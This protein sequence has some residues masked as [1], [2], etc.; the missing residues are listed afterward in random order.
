MVPCIRSVR[1]RKVGLFKE[2]ETSICL[3]GLWYRDVKAKTHTANNEA[4]MKNIVVD[5][6]SEPSAP[7]V[8]TT[9]DERNLP[10]LLPDCWT[11]IMG[12]C[13]A[14]SLSSLD[15]TSR[16]FSRQTE[17]AWNH[18]AMMRFGLQTKSSSD[19]SSCT[20]QQPRRAKLHA[21]RRGL[22]LT[23]P[24]RFTLVEL[25][26]NVESGKE[27]RATEVAQGGGILVHNEEDQEGETDE[28][29]T[30]HNPLFL[31]DATTL[32][33][34]RTLPNPF[35]VWAVTVC[36]MTDCEIVVTSNATE[37]M[38]HRGDRS[39]TIHLSDYDYESS[40]FRSH[41]AITRTGIGLLGSEKSLVV[42][43]GGTLYVF[44]VA[45]PGG[46]DLPL[47]KFTFSVALSGEALGSHAMCWAC[48]DLP[49]SFGMVPTK[50][51]IQVWHLS[52]TCYRP[53]RVQDIAYRL[54]QVQD[55]DSVFSCLAVGQRYIAAST[56]DDGKKI[57]VFDRGNGLE[58]WALG[59]DQT[60]T[61]QDCIWGISMQIVGDLLVSSSQLGNAL[62]IWQM[63]TGTLLRRYD[64]A[65]HQGIS[66]YHWRYPRGED[67]ISL[68]RLNTFGCG[69][70][71]TISF[72]MFLWA[73]PEDSDSAFR[74]ECLARRERVLRTHWRTSANRSFGSQL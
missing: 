28:N 47:L 53:T 37:L 6:A 31:R 50:D 44:R 14:N 71:I 54:T 23:Q 52:E 72:N 1:S 67:V 24:K 39:Q 55:R 21:W 58:K 17:S 26:G 9:V 3:T 66:D 43:G 74:V 40:V 27:L 36:G 63:R 18:L 4:I 42:F 16:T 15:A 62:C 35:C 5:E 46:K 59:D 33:V 73:F 64:D 41:P 38:A 29:I 65:F 45:M 68:T 19:D 51:S 30:G 22:A 57:H 20:G 25:S 60:E 13:D 10:E 34:I 8:S 61:V 2:E 12:F 70:F 7:G 69:A 48:D 56:P 32:G 49:E 11:R